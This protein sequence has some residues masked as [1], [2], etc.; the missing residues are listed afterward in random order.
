MLEKWAQRDP[1]KD[2]ERNGK[3]FFVSKGAI[4]DNK[5]DLSIN[6]YRH[7]EHEQIKHDSPIVIIEQLR[8]L[9]TSILSDLAL[10]QEMIR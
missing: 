6:R 2:T 4:V 5:Y 8:E 1:K 10:L 7:V 9:E 3:A